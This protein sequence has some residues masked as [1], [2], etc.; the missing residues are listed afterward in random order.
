MRCGFCG[1]W[2]EHVMPA[3]QFM[4]ARLICPDCLRRFE[5]DFWRLRRLCMA[6]LRRPVA[7]WLG[8]AW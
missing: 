5:R 3:P 8:R 4:A 6:S 7:E 1:Y 2:S